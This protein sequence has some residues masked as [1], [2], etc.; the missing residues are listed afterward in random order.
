MSKRKSSG[1]KASR[2]AQ[3]KGLESIYKRALKAYWSYDFEL[4]KAQIIIG[5]DTVNDQDTHLCLYRL[6]IEIL[7]KQEDR[8]GLEL[9]SNHFLEIYQRAEIS[10]DFYIALV[11]LVYIELDEVEKAELFFR[12][13][14]NASNHVYL[15]ECRLRLAFRKTGTIQGGKLSRFAGVVFDYIQ[16]E[17]IAGIAIHENYKATI[18]KVRDQLFD[19]YPDSPML[20]LLEVCADISKQKF[21]A[22]HKLTSELITN[23]PN[24]TLIQQFHL[25]LSCQVGGSYFN[26]DLLDSIEKSSRNPEILALSALNMFRL[27][28]AFKPSATKS[29]M[30]SSDLLDRSLEIA[31]KEGRVTPL[32][33]HQIAAHER[34]NQDHQAV[35][36]S[37]IWLVPLSNREFFDIRTQREKFETIR[38]PMGGS[39][40]KGDICI[41]VCEDKVRKGSDDNWRLAAI[42]SAV[43]Y[44]QWHPLHRYESVLKRDFMPEVAIPID[45]SFF[46]ESVSKHSYPYGDTRRYGIHHLDLDGLA[47]IERQL[48]DFSDEFDGQPEAIFPLRKAL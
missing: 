40:A 34:A 15:E 33:Y 31:R 2:A 47:S 16:F 4:A 20:M 14:K 6:W 12:T 38:R 24:N 43:D 19:D 36:A 48:E 18:A 5:L 13:I 1:K 21:N 44:P 25:A 28:Q 27:E 46:V 45:C 37:N 22:A 10:S 23:F 8:S 32:V 35:K 26:K 17:F 9:L 11:T 30:N 3:P 39:I 7:A 42:Y 41:F 29:E